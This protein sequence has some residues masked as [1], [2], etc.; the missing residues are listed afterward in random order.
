L[1][2]D[3]SVFYHGDGK[4]WIEIVGMMRVEVVKDGRDD[5]VCQVL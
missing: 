3:V 4:P 2:G 5:A 1:P